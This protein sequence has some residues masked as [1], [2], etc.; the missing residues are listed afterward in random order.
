MV[1]SNE[2]VSIYTEQELE[3]LQE[4]ISTGDYNPFED[5]RF[6]A[7]IKA[8]SAEDAT[9]IEY[10]K[11][12]QNLNA[13]LTKVEQLKKTDPSYTFLSD[14][15][16]MH[17]LADMD[18][19]LLQQLP[20]DLFANIRDAVE[21]EGIED[22]NVIGNFRSVA[23]VILDKVPNP[24][25]SFTREQMA[26]ENPAFVRAL[27]NLEEAVDALGREKAAR[28]GRQRESGSESEGGQSLE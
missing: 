11:A 1:Y 21:Q 19:E 18:Q 9:L 15:E 17:M 28:E 6:M 12:T 4:R 20:S 3:N 2:P 16:T 14:K 26:L 25:D 7:S 10:L 23:Q 13:C 24:M 5:P 27:D 8:A 22:T